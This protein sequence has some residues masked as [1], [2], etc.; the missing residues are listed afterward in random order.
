MIDAI[1]S[2][3]KGELMEEFGSKFNLDSSQS[4]RVA[5]VS[6]HSL[7]DTLS[8]HLASG[9]VGDILQLLNGEAS[10]NSNPIVSNMVG[11]LVSSLM[12][13]LGLSSTM[14]T[15]LSNYVVP[16][17]LDK[18][19]AKKPSNGFDISSLTELISGGENGLADS[20]KSALGDS[21]SNK[22]GKLFG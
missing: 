3:V 22:F 17:V 7:K 4:V 15:S 12:S 11:N 13:K 21:I 10:I 5:E 20:M 19:A 18:I 1:F 14:A 2:S 8:K 6:E 16:F 9:N